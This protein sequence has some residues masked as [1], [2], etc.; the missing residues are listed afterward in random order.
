MN[1]DSRRA[2]KAA[3]TREQILDRTLD[4][5]DELG[6]ERA[7][8]DE[9][10]RRA[11]VTWGAIQHHF[12]SRDELLMATIERSFSELTEAI[13]RGGPPGQTGLDRLQAV[14]DVMWAYCSDR[15]YRIAWEI[16][17]HLRRKPSCASLIDERLH[18]FQETFDD[19]WNAMFQDALGGKA[20]QVVRRTLF[21]AMRG[22]ALLKHAQVP[23]GDF[24]QERALLVRLL[25]VE[26]D[27][28]SSQNGG[29]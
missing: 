26:L 19:S 28:S 5:I 29:R 21:G 27:S 12:G 3:R 7:S 23:P 9:I 14:A 17:L 25:A 20:D 1:A 2:L 15:R 4:C 11:E 22:F 6:L 18:T 13:G 16:I 24:V 8:S 10:A